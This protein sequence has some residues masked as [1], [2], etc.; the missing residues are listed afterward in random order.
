MTLPNTR[1]GP[2]IREVRITPIAI[3]DP[4]LL[5]AAGLHAPYALR[6]IVE[7]VTE[8]GISGISEIP[9]NVATNDALASATH[10][11]TGRDVFQQN[12]IRQVLTEHFGTENAAQRGL[13]PWDQRKLVHIFSAVEVAC[14]D[15]VGKVTNRPVVDLLG[16]KL[17]DQVPFSAYL[18]YKY[19]GA[20]GEL[21]FGSDPAAQGWSAA[22]QAAALDPAGIVA[23]AQAMCAE[24]GFQSIKLK[25]GVFDPSDEVA[26][27]FALRDAFGPDRPGGALPL[28]IDPNALWTVETAIRYG[29]Q[30]EPILEYLE[31]P[32]R[33]QANMATVRKALKTPLATNMCTTSFD[34]IP[35][36][37]AL[38]SEDIILSDHHFWGGLRASMTLA[39]ICDTFG[40]G[41]SMHSNSHLGISLAAMV[42]LGAALP[43]LTYALDTH[44]PWQS[45]E[46]IKGGRFR[47][48]DGAVAVPTEPGLGVE[49]DHEALARLHQNY[50]TCGL[51]ERN[52]EIEMQK[53][54][55]GWQ[56]QATRW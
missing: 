43:N 21:G 31:D 8:D 24:F 36:S 29:R 23:Q 26:A 19:E 9:G 10:L 5:N 51:T 50:L 2:C 11:L 48:D 17:R 20:G 35:A 14:L 39:G 12:T 18:F 41:L 42:H 25:G 54:N 13:T 55:P 49:L 6:T 32:V 53:V 16:G 47:F 44:Y 46:V 40:R 38:G 7:L 52:D 56:F 1:T 15:I 28:R 45:D 37:I 22:R 33:G 34:D 4:P 30:L 3:V 27:M